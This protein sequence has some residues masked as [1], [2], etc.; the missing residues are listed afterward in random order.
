MFCNC[1]YKDGERMSAEDE[2]VIIDKLLAH[3]PHAEDKI[4]CGLDSIMV[5]RSCCSSFSLIVDSNQPYTVD[6]GIIM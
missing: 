6:C 1:R 2:K 3:H 4:G 5:R